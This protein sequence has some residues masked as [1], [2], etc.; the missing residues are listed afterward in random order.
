LAAELA[1]AFAAVPLTGA[2]I[3]TTRSALAAACAM[4]GEPVMESVADRR[5]AIGNGGRIGLRLYRPVGEIG[6]V[7]VWAHGGGFALG[8][9]DEI[10]NFAR[11]LAG[12]TR[13]AVASVAYR[14]APEHKFPAALDDFEAAAQWI[15]D[16]CATIGLGKVPVW[17]GGDSAGGNLATVA[18]RRLH[19][20]GGARIAG[21]ILAYPCTDGPD[22]ES[23]R[24]F[25]PPFM[26]AEDIAWFM[27]M[28]LPDA[29]TRRHPDF[30]PLHAEGLEVLPPTLL[31]TAEHDILT[32]QCEAYAARLAEAGVPTQVSRQSGMIH[33]FLTLDPFLAGA[34]T[35]AI[36]EIGAFLAE[37]RDPPPF[38]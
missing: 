3:E 16:N 12:R 26:R 34:T 25:E 27:E 1:A 36:D 35:R 22:A 29:A 14:L 11:L 10:D 28:Y 18:T 30:A 5:I 15:F 38:G 2:P 20:R 13:C 19:A 21:N 8:T 31:L 33:G 7:I 9:L 4:R 37:H 24:G 32:E 6:A 17:L 23:L